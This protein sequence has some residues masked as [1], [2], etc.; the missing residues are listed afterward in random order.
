M[1]I[2]EAVRIAGGQTAL[3]LAIGVNP[4]TVRRWVAGDS[5]PSTLA[6]AAIKRVIDR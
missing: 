4:R 2:K 1:S 6:L 3:A 5:A